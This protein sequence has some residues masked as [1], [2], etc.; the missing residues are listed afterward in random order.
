MRKSAYVNFLLYTCLFIAE[1]FLQLDGV[2][3][4]VA[5]MDEDETRAQA[6]LSDIRDLSYVQHKLSTERKVLIALY[7]LLI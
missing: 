1:F 3:R 6:L 5:E 2:H 4:D 7:C